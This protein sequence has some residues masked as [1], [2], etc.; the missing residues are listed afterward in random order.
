MIWYLVFKGE[1][2]LNR[3]DNKKRYL[4]QHLFQHKQMGFF[5]TILIFTKE[6]GKN[7]KKNPDKSALL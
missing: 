5:K 4:K 6:K 1:D 7:R 2:K 3:K